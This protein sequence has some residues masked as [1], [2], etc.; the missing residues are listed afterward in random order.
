MDLATLAAFGLGFIAGAFL[1]H[2]AHNR[3]RGYVM[4]EERR[5]E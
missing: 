4:T 2:Y 5:E 1:T 3:F